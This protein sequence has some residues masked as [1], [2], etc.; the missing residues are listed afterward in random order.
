MEEN[1]VIHDVNDI[2]KSTSL[3]AEKETSHRITTAEVDASLKELLKNPQIK[4][5]IEL[6]AQN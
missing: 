2:V 4:L 3:D 1:I 6:L 5:A